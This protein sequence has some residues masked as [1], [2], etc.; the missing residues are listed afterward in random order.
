MSPALAHLQLPPVFKWNIFPV[1]QSYPRLTGS[2]QSVSAW[3]FNKSSMLLFHV[4][5]EAVDALYGACSSKGQ[6]AE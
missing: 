5:W 4:P 1:P 6:E 2:K 3:W